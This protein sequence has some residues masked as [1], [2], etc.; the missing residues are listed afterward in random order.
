MRSIVAT[1]KNPINEVSHLVSLWYFALLHPVSTSRS[2]VVATGKHNKFDLLLLLFLPSFAFALLE[3]EGERGRERGRNIER[4]DR[5]KSAPSIGPT[6][7]DRL[8]E[9]KLLIKI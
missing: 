7:R 5:Y 8:L 9:V 1:V 6:D 3:R 4:I 2:D